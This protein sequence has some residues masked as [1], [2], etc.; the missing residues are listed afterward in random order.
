MQGSCAQAGAVLRPLV[1]LN[2]GTVPTTPPW[3]SL[4]WLEAQPAPTPWLCPPDWSQGTQK[5]QPAIHPRRSSGRSGCPWAERA[6]P[7]ESRCWAAPSPGSTDGIPVGEAA[8][9]SGCNR[10]GATCSCPG[11]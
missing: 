4:G 3:A 8:A 7:R 5:P 1:E 10:A 6:V 11:W 2:V 9:V